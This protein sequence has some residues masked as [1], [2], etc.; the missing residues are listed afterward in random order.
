MVEEKKRVAVLA[1]G[2]GV[3][4]V[5]STAAQV[6]VSLI[7]GLI[8]PGLLEKMWFQ[9]IASSVCLYGCGMVPGWLI[10]RRMDMEREPRQRMRALTLAAVVSVAVVALLAGSLA[11]T[12]VNFLITLVTGKEQTNPV[13]TIANGVPLGVLTLCTVILAPVAEELFFRRVLIDRLRRYGDIPAILCSAVIFG[14]AHGNFSQ[15]FYAFLLGLIFGGMYC[16]T[17]RL[18]YSI[19][20][21]MAINFFGSVYTTLLTRRVG[22]AFTP[23]ALIADPV[24]LLMYLGLLAVY[25]LAILA[26]VPS[27]L[28]LIHRFHPQ[29]QHT[30]YTA[31]QW[32]NIVLLNPAVWIDCAVFAVRF[33][34]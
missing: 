29:R 16:A 25:G 18:R 17:G 2:V 13:E 26:F 8:A 20:L 32:A 12:V 28:L 21:H 1:A 19:G 14:L 31:G 34:L 30:A 11:G 27:L 10:L 3:V 5:G 33:L 7:C 4:F 6:A 9:L 23:A 15:F 24:A 22:T